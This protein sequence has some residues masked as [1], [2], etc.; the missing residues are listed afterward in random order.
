[1]PEDRPIE[2]LPLF[3]SHAHLDLDSFDADRES[4]LERAA[5]AGVQ[6][7]VMPGITL[8]NSAGLLRLTEAASARADDDPPSARPRLF[9]AVGV[10]PNS[11]GDFAHAQAVER[12]I[13]RLQELAAHPSVV[14]IGEIG[15]DNYWKDVEPA[16]QE[17]AFRRQL[18]LAAELGK[19]VIIHS[20]DANEQVAAVLRD[21]VG[22]SHFRSS[23]LAQ[24][25]FAGVL[26]AFSG[27]LTLAEEAYG[28]GFVLGLGGPV[29]F[30]GARALHQLAP[31]LALDR[32]MLETD[33]PYLTP[34][35]HRGARNEPAHLPLVCQALATLTG[36]APLEVAQ[37]TTAVA[38]QFFGLE[39][40]F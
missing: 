9:A 34:H 36:H 37:T 15:L 38:V 4:M 27:D 21:W 22:G 14:A 19:P 5:Q 28:W 35:P 1:M 20:R 23:P 10:H 13:S 2:P 3:D 7:V 12:T 8:R 11:S 33:S 17:L 26:H 32:L 29:T 18:A 24:R 40:R 25:P 31:A 16:V 39:S 30:K 6:A